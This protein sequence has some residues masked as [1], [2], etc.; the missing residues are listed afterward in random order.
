M[1]DNALQSVF[2]P[3]R[4]TF[5]KYHR[6]GLDNMYNDLPG[7]RKVILESLEA[8]API[9]RSRPGSLNLQIYLTSKSKELIQLFSQSEAKE[10]NEAVSIL[11]R[12]DP[13]NSSKYQEILN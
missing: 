2:K 4:A 6:E 10:K 9:Q 5:Y 3:L 11:K 13:A 8:L 7:S 12:L 1:V